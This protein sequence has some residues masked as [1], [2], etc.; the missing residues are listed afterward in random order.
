MEQPLR[1]RSAEGRIEAVVIEL[2][3]SQPLS[4]I[5][6]ARVVHLADVC[7]STF[8]RH[9]S[10]V[11]EVYD[12]AVENL[13]SRCE[14]LF[15]SVFLKESLTYEEITDSLISGNLCPAAFAFDAHDSILVRHIINHSFDDFTEALEKRLVNTLLRGIPHCNEDSDAEFQCSFLIK[16]ISLVYLI[17][18]YRGAAFDTAHIKVLHEYVENLKENRV[19]PHI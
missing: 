18:F 10:D 5:T 7:R 8:Y 15:E 19:S 9:Y 14:A 6:V 3:Q 1:R 17:D 4:E 12:S 16:S 11:F 2:L 13:M